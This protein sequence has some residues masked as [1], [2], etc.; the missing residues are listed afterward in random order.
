MMIN[1][2]H[3]RPAGTA[4][5]AGPAEPATIQATVIV[6]T[7]FD[8]VADG[9]NPRLMVPSNDDARHA[10]VMSDSGT[11]IF[12]LDIN[13]NIERDDENE[14]VVADFDLLYES[15]LAVKKKEVDLVVEG[16]TGSAPISGSINIDGTDWM[17]RVAKALPLT[18]DEARNLF[19]WQRR[20]ETP[21]AITDD[22][23]PKDDPVAAMA[24]YG[25]AFNNVYRRV[26][27]FTRLV[28][29][30]A[31]LP[32]GGVVTIAN[33]DD[34]YAFRLP[35]PLSMEARHFT[36]CGHG[37]D[38]APRWNPSP[39]FAM[40]ADTLIVTPAD[41][42]AVILWRGG[43]RYADHAPDLYRAVHVANAGRL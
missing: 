8:L 14:P 11:E 4:F 12:K 33:A 3:D 37:I 13:G 34:T 32:D 22:S 23:T 19:G 39:V 42:R 6:R 5:V 2:L 16:F 26:P 10:V 35:D 28:A 20:D 15:D 29:E 41:H 40:R 18:P 36:Y 7:A 21:R 9:G 1:L 17:R 25:I 43:W 30:G 31:N 24:G 38:E 27:E